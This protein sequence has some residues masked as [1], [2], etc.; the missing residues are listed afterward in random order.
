MDGIY[1]YTQLTRVIAP[2]DPLIVNQF[3]EKAVDRVF[4]KSSAKF[5]FVKDKLGIMR[6]R[7][8]VYGMAEEEDAKKELIIIEMD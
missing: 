3:S 5:I 4:T 6:L 1:R 7:N 2:N 8:T